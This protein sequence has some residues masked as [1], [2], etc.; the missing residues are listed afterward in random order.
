MK[1]KRIDSLQIVR[2]L[3]CIGIFASHSEIKCL[4]G[5]G[6]WG[7]SI[8]LVLSGFLM[9]YNHIDNNENMNLSICS[10][11][12]YGLNKIKRLYPLYVI[13]MTLMVPF[14]LV[15]ADRFSSAHALLIWALNLGLMQ[16]WIPLSF[17]SPNAPGWFLDAILLSYI[18]FPL[19]MKKIGGVHKKEG[20]SHNDYFVFIANSNWNNWL[21]STN[22]FAYVE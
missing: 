10:S 19:V 11:I 16:E 14:L 15:G 1:K 2:A 21:K 7:V 8:F 12:E 20:Y 17:R 5:F 3:A 22:A 18:V 13:S 6:P 4:E 9:V